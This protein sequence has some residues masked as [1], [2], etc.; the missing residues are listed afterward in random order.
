MSSEAIRPTTI[1][2]IKRLA[3]TL[4]SEL[5]VPH[6]RA[7]NLAA[8][9]AGFE[10]FGHAENR[11]GQSSRAA[12]QAPAH[13]VYLTAYWKD[14]TSGAS[15]RE[16]LSM[17]MSR[18]WTEL[19]Q[20][21]HFVNHR[22]LM[23]FR[24]EAPDHLARRN[25]CSSAP[26]A[27]RQICALSRTL[28]FMAATGLRPTKSHSRAYPGGN[29]GNA[30]P[31]RDHGSV[32]YDP[33]TKRYLMVDEP[34]E[35]SAQEHAGERQAW[36][37]AHGYDV[38]KPSWAGMYAPDVGSRLYLISHRAKGVPLDELLRALNALPEPLVEEAWN[39]E[40]APLLPM[41]VS[42]GTQSQVDKPRKAAAAS[43][44]PPAPRNSVGYVRTFVGPQRRPKNR[45]PL[46]VHEQAGKLLKEVLSLTYYRKG[47][48]NR[49]G[50]VRS[51]LDEWVQRE[52]TTEAELPNE[53]F[54]KIYYGGGSGERSQRQ[55]PQGERERLR[56]KLD[57]VSALLVA[58]YVDC[59]P[60]RNLL[61]KLAGAQDSLLKWA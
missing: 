26:E 31:G 46:E 56:G 47:A 7:L 32:W 37:Q 60:L 1:V 53:R 21:Q 36:A 59:V 58:N 40:S 49:V 28:Q 18:P 52:Y 16:T 41:F 43:R 30:I 29:P 11:L 27:R 61:K 8:H 54:V 14:Q 38:A 12:N 39:G 4:K 34:Y 42:P 33:K 45:M 3:K 57:Q 44:Q 50:L 55:M 13:L 20:P 35:R 6:H 5:R 2:G 10:N 19:I 17:P 48:H 24:P 25:L 9:A 51:E 22:A 15:G 23:H